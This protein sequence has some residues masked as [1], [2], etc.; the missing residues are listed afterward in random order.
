MKFNCR[1]CK[2]EMY[3]FREYL[4]ITE[5]ACHGH[6][7]DGTPCPNNLDEKFFYEI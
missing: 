3:I 4:H 1:Y 7:C 5:W 6:N 2:E